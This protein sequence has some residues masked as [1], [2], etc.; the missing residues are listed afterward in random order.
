[1]QPKP[2]VLIAD[3]TTPLLDR[4]T[5]SLR[6]K[7]YQIAT[8]TTGPA[9]LSM[10]KE[11]HPQLLVVDLMI[12]QIHGIEILKRLKGNSK[13][14]AIGIIVTSHHIMIQ[15]YESAVEVG[16]NYF[17][18]KPFS[19]DSLFHLIDQYFTSKL[20]PDP[21]SSITHTIE[22]QNHCYYPN[23]SIFSSY[24]KFWGT[25]GSNPV[26]GAHYAHY[27]GNTSCLEIKS[28]DH[29]V[30]IDAGTGIRELGQELHPE[31][32]ETLHIFISHTHWDHI[33]GFP[34]FSPLYKRNCTIIVWA[35]IG[36]EK[37]TKELFT[38][39]LAHSYFPV[40]LDEMKAQISFRELRD[41]HPI[42][43]GNLL[44][45]THFTNHP[46]PTLGF[47]IKTPNI[48]FGYV[49]DNEMLLGYVGRPNAIH[50]KHPLLE[51]HLNLIR[52]F[53]ECS[54]MIH[55]AQYFPSEYGRKI[56]W[57]HSS[58]A[59][60]TVLIK[61][62]GVKEWIITHHDPNHTDQD[63]Q[64]KIQL[65]SDIAADC[66]LQLNMRIAYDGLVIPI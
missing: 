63:L 58:I 40:R 52:F 59:N 6:A 3:P 22:T 54:L 33:T 66:N 30:I 43:I 35:P 60:A 47:K 61:Y 28:G 14:V 48:S 34:F 10:I 19:V 27:G 45:D 7:H 17:L 64:K 41:H 13:T 29:R 55:E 18:A 56:G 50:L 20:T 32:G 5:A 53:K 24:L 21:F 12:P 31:E 37:N 23:S 42:S 51:P 49:T 2:R 65:H 62:I 16:V 25:R 26:S 11:F 44:I 46:G 9:T 38:N 4:I 1:M 15:N 57:G 8:T 36:F 39:M